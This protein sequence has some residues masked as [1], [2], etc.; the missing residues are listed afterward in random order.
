M[1]TEILENGSV[2][3]Y[4]IEERRTSL[5]IPLQEVYSNLERNGL[6]NEKS[7]ISRYYGG[8]YFHIVKQCGLI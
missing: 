8:V 1:L 4:H 3:V 2:E 5:C 7:L 6:L